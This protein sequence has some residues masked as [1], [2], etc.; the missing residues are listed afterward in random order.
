MCS[1][2][3]F[4]K[5]FSGVVTLIKNHCSSKKSENISAYGTKSE[6]YFRLK[7]WMECDFYKKSVYEKLIDEETTDSYLSQSE[8]DKM[9]FDIDHWFSKNATKKYDRVITSLHEWKDADDEM[10][11]LFETIKDGEYE[12]YSQ[13]REA[14]IDEISKEEPRTMLDDLEIVLVTPKPWRNTGVYNYREIEKKCLEKE[15]HYR[16]SVSELL[17]A[18][19]KEIGHC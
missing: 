3:D 7:Q 13:I 18:M 5:I 2:N 14:V 1:F 8:L 15:R 6:I 10:N 12:C 4:I 9:R 16:D 19:K 11:E 17:N